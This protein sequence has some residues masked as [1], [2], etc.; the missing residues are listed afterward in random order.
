MCSCVVCVSSVGK[1]GVPFT[2]GGI[3]RLLGRMKVRGFDGEGVGGLSKKV[4]E[5]MKVT[6]TVLGSPRVLILSRPATK[7]SPGREVHFHGLVDRLSRR[8]LILLSARVMSSVRCV[9]GGVVLVGSKR[10]F[11]TNATRSLMSSVGR[12]M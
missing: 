8:H 4:I 2:E 12:G 9:T 10:L 6:R 5:H 11:C 3:G 7:L 1:L